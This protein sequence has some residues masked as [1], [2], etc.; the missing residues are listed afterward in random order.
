MPFVYDV[1][2]TLL[3]V[4]A[5]TREAAA[6]KGMEGFAPVADEVS[7]RWRQRQLSL[8]W[9]RSLMGEY[10][11]FWT[12]TQDALDATLG[13]MGLGSDALRSRLLDLYLRLSAYGEVRGELEAARAAGHGLGVLSNGNPAMLE[14]A[15]GSAGILGLFDHVLSADTLKVYKP[16]PPVYRLAADAFGCA[17]GEVTFFSSNNWD[18]AGAGAFGF[19]TVWVNRAGRVWD[20]PPPGPAHEVSSLKAGHA[21]ATVAMRDLGLV[22]DGGN[23][24]VGDMN[25][26]RIQGLIDILTPIFTE[27][28]VESF[29]PN[30]TPDDVY[31]NEFLDPSI[32]LGF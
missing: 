1:Y 32:S 25:G 10:A 22:T 6:E 19:R 15:L 5:A 30:V 4:D 9:L 28:G 29:D 18:V 16:H 31:T 8:T 23:G 13:E 3:D 7:R 26:D 21:A 24:F 12:V 17:P 20:A 2:G 11:D 27:Q 14:S